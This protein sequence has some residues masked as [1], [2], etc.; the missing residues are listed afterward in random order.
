MVASRRFFPQ[1]CQDPAVRSAVA[2]H[3]WVSVTPLQLSMSRRGH[4]HVNCHCAWRPVSIAGR[5]LTPLQDS[6]RGSAVAESGRVHHLAPDSSHAR[7]WP[8]REL[9]GGLG[10]P[11]RM[12]GQGGGYGTCPHA[13]FR[14]MSHGEVTAGSPDGI[15]AGS[16]AMRLRPPANRASRLRW[17]VSPKCGCEACSA[18]V[19]ELVGFSPSRCCGACRSSP[20]FNC[21]PRVRLSLTND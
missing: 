7:S 12:R 3:P 14:S 18:S 6:D 15:A 19:K 10:S 20:D 4:L 21:C 13:A 11:A 16:A 8:R 1:N 9:W 17:K 5:Y 2:T